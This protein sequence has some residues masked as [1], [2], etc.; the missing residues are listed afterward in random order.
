MR[1]PGRPDIVNA[2]PGRADIEND[3]PLLYI[4]CAESR[5]VGGTSCHQKA[6]ARGGD[7]TSLPAEGERAAVS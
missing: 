3:I 5:A 4:A 2:G 1:G 6:A 7:K